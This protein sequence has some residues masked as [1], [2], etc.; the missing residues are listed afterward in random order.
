MPRAGWKDPRAREVLLSGAGRCVGLRCSAGSDSPPVQ[1]VGASTP[2]GQ[3]APGTGGTLSGHKTA[4]PGSGSSSS[5]RTRS[6]QQTFSI[7]NC[8]VCELGPSAREGKE[9]ELGEGGGG[10]TGFSA[11][12]RRPRFSQL[13]G[14]ERALRAEGTARA[15]A[16]VAWCAGGRAGRPVWPQQG[17]RGGQGQLGPPGLH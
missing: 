13:E 9:I 15:G 2:V 8:R 10:A 16:G 14:G 7:Q 1:Q 11:V 5:G 12:A 17:S 3:A 6:K 4:K